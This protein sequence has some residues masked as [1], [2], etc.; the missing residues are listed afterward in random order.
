[1]KY[2]F[3]L[4]LL[5]ILQFSNAQY[6]AVLTQRDQARVIDDLLEDRLRNVLPT[7]M[8]RE[9]FDMWVV[10]AREYNEDPVIARYHHPHVKTFPAHEAGQRG[11]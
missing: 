9:G 3:S 7:L 11:A 2:F 10:I 5:L 8:R 1:M 4:L 6:P